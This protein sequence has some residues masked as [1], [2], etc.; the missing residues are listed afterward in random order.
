MSSSVLQ[1]EDL[2][3]VTK[4][5][6]KAWLKM[7]KR[8]ISIFVIGIKRHTTVI[9]LQT[10]NILCST[11]SALNFGHSY[12]IVL[13]DF[14]RLMGFVFLIFPYLI[15][16]LL[17]FFIDFDILYICQCILPYSTYYFS[18][19]VIKKGLNIVRARDHRSCMTNTL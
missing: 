2:L 16:S 8:P 9:Y 4:R 12:G 6:R 19:T 18:G 13:S 17:K 5:H 7:K 11:N 3:I 1:F 15:F 14:I 10:S